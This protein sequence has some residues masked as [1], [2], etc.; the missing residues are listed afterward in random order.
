MITK[1]LANNSGCVKCKLSLY[2]LGQS[3]IVYACK[4]SENNSI[5]CVGLC[6]IIHYADNFMYTHSWMDGHAATESQL[7]V[8]KSPIERNDYNYVQYYSLHYSYVYSLFIL[9]QFLKII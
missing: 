1:I 5:D 8:E 4:E 6:K 9:Y 3:R 7:T 2:L